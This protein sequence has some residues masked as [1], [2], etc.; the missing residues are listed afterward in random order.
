MDHAALAAWLER[1]VAAWASYDADAIGD[2]FAEDARYRYHPHEEPLRGRAAIVAEW[3]ADRDPAGTYDARYEPYAVDGERAV[4]I[5][6]STYFADPD[7]SRV[8]RVYD[9]CFALEFD[10]DGRCRSF[11]EWYA[12]RPADGGG[13]PR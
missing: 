7:R 1:Y 3:L 12:Q 6:T 11:T 9:N 2:L 10:G 8:D 13:E 4:A 5:G